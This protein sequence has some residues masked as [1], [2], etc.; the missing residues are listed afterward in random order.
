M[1][2]IELSGP[3]ILTGAAAALC[4]AVTRGFMH[5][6]LAAVLVIL[7]SAPIRGPSERPAGRSF[8]TRSWCTRGT[9]CV[10]AA[11]PM[12]VQIGGDVLK[13]GGSEV[14]AAIRQ[15]RP[16][17]HGADVVRDRRRPVRDRV[18]REDP[19]PLGLNA[20]GRAPRALT[21]D[22]VKPN[23]R[24]HRR[25]DPALDGAGAVNGWFALHERL[26]GSR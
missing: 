23:R 15:R 20:S 16:R 2:M 1:T 6:R 4:F 3:A 21:A 10:A 26:G 24:H 17:V 14:D 19:A 12:A 5:R 11:H 9:G 7:L 18:G 22:K 25:H 8:A 13:K